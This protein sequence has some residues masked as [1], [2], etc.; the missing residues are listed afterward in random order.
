MEQITENFVSALERA[1]RQTRLSRAMF[2]EDIETMKEY[3]LE[4]ILHVWDLIEK[5]D[6][7]ETI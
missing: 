5:I 6:L 1:K 2:F 4:E 3:T 7:M